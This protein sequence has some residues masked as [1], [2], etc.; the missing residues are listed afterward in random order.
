MKNAAKFL[1]ISL[2]AVLI[3]GC[4]FFNT[5]YHA[6]KSYNAGIL[7]IKKSREQAQAAVSNKD[8]S[9]DRFSLE[10]GPL[11][12]D[13]KNA[14][15]IAI[16]KANK[17]IVLHPGSG[18]VEN[19]ILLSGKAQYL[20]GQ[21]SDLFDARNRFEVFLSKYPESKYAA[22]ARLWYGKTLWRMN[23]V[24]QA[25]SELE[26]ITSGKTDDKIAAQAMITLGDIE[27]QRGSFDRAAK[28][29]TRAAAL[30]RHA[31]DRKEA[32]Y[33]ASYAYYST[34]D[35]A[36]AIFY[37]DQLVR[38][39][40]EFQEKFDA[41]FMR[42]RMLKEKGEYDS[43]I[44]ILDRLLGNPKYGNLFVRA[45]YEIGDILRLQGRNE[46]A[47]SQLLHVI[48]T[49]NNSAFVG[50]CYYTLGLMYDD[51]VLAGVDGFSADPELALK[52]FQTVK[53]R[54]GSSTFFPE[55]ISRVDRA[56]TLSTYHHAIT[57][58]ETLLLSVQAR[59]IDTTNT[60]QAFWPSLF[61][62][63]DTADLQDQL[64]T[65]EANSDPMTGIYR[66]RLSSPEKDEKQSW[67][68]QFFLSLR[69]LTNQDSLRQRETFLLNRIQTDYALLADYFYYELA[70]LDSAYAYYAHLAENTKDKY[71]EYALYGIA[72]VMQKKNHPE[73]LSFFKNALDEFPNG[74]LAPIG[75]RVLGMPQEN[76]SP[77]ARL[78]AAESMALI[79]NDYESAE[80]LYLQV[81]LDDTSEY[82]WR[83]L[84]A[85]GWLNER[86]LDRTEAAFRYYQTLI[87]AKPQSQFA[88]QVRSKCEAFAKKNQLSPDSL[89][90]FVDTRFVT[91]RKPSV[92]QSTPAVSDSA[93]IPS[94]A[95]T[96]KVIDSDSEFKRRG[97]VPLEKDGEIRKSKNIKGTRT[98]SDEKEVIKEDD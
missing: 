46:A 96:A 70:E 37:M 72:R 66:S 14:F 53:T 2:F 93:R 7:S 23:L 84:Y 15:D 48:T 82:R 57:T 6:R 45:E 55:A 9:P 83:A 92:V 29:Y 35:L 97:R 77:E 33:K 32:L 19:A 59:M 25:I 38:M 58:D 87:Y 89:V 22:E 80:R 12:T 20:R 28:Q 41:Q 86:K 98:T 4:A 50:D 39:D 43:A 51:P 10:A 3:G 54:Y 36:S 8:V 5:Y 11:P 44:R 49:Y 63:S 56:I 18:W 17:V 40:L 27:W 71:R 88:Q 34:H 24:A 73:Y 81:A 79:E 95:D 47:K 67:S 52:F 74:S 76:N 90:K 60:L 69:D 62:V 85:L 75:R 42:A 21:S 16:E 1:V 61:S 78:E 30:S 13:A 94:M 26:Q 65:S 64:P 68:E 31:P 91:I